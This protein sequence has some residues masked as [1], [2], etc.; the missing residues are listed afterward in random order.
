MPASIIKKEIIP[1]IQRD[2][3]YLAREKIRVLDG[4]GKELDPRSINWS[5]ERAANYILRQDSGAGNSAGA[6]DNS[7][8]VVLIGTYGTLDQAK[9]VESDIHKDY[10]AAHVQMPSGTNSFYRVII[11]PYDKRD[12]DKVASELSNKRKGIMILPWAEN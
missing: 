2:P 5:S 7:R 4:Q 12:A 3:S 11:G 9:Q 8:F 10:L 6:N 1:H